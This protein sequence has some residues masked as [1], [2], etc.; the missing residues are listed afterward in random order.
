[1]KTLALSNLSLLPGS[2]LRGPEWA[3]NEARHAGFHALKVNPLYGWDA[4]VLRRTSVP[5][6]AFQAPWRFSFIDSVI[7]LVKNGDIIGFVADIFFF[8][9]LANSRAE[10]YGNA[11]EDAVGVDCPES[12][13]GRFTRVRETEYAKWPDPLSGNGFVCLDT[14]HIRSY[15]D[16]ETL[17]SKLVESEKIA[18]VDIQTRDY[19][20]FRAFL[21]E[22]PTTLGRQ[23]DMLKWLPDTVSVSVELLPQHI[24]RLMKDFS[25]TRSEV[26]H[27]V[28]NRIQMAIK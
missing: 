25:M 26:L 22:Q 28:Q 27:L 14:W 5:V 21:N 13:C 1:M 4:S 19:A 23:L 6:S 7:N 10:M 20:E 2:L 9:P 16:H 24:G 3:W 17:I 12:Y 8:G 15:P 11:F 18:A